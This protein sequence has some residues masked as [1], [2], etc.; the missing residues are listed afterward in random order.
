MEYCL[1]EHN[2]AYLGILD[3]GRVLAQQQTGTCTRDAC[4]RDSAD[5]VL[6]GQ[7]LRRTVV[8][9]QVVL[10][11]L[12]K[13]RHPVQEIPCYHS[14]LW[15]LQETIGSIRILLEVFFSA[16]VSWIP[17]MYSV[18]QLIRASV[19]WLAALLWARVRVLLWARVRVLLQALLWVLLRALLRVLLQALLWVLLRALLRVLLR[20][21]RRV[22]LRLRILHTYGAQSAQAMLHTRQFPTLRLLS[23]HTTQHSFLQWIATKNDFSVAVFY[24]DHAPRTSK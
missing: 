9:P 7:R 2:R 20:V 3:L 23:T 19:L 8:L 18:H 13:I 21:L 15:T 17:T 4:S 11:I 5:T 12:P 16:P 1:C 22:L 24:R 6:P 14:A 10:G